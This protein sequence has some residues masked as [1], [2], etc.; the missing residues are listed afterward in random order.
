MAGLPEATRTLLLVA[1]LDDGGV[2][3]EVLSAAALVAGEE[4]G[5]GRARPA[6]A[7]QLV[8][9]DADAVRFRHPLVRSAIAQAVSAAERLD[10][11]AALARVLADQ[12]HRRVWH[13]AASVVGTDEQVAAEL[14]AAAGSAQQRGSSLAA[15]AALER[16]ARM[17][18]GAGRAR[19][20]AAACRRARVRA[21]ARA[22]SWGACSTRSRRSRSRRWIAR[23]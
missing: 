8:E 16:A 14:E 9:V 13:R 23:V 1:A 4:L 3:A 18:A 19:R 12:P 11:H 20:P 5:A 21:R 2:P 17:S 7:A 6:V 10:A 22:M 15:I